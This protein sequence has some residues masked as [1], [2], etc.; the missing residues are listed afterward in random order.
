M[1]RAASPVM[2]R[3]RTRAVTEHRVGVLELGNSEN[4]NISTLDAL[5][6]LYGRSGLAWSQRE[7]AEAVF[8]PE[9]G[10]SL[11]QLLSRIAG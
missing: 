5:D 2:C 3:G 4:E 8:S 11:Q 9:G 6:A 1:W 10:V 7:A